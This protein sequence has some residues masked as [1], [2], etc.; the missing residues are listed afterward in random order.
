MGFRGSRVRISPARPVLRTFTFP[1]QI[2]PPTLAYDRVRRCPPTFAFTCLP[3][4]YQRTRRDVGA[5]HQA[6]RGRSGARYASPVSLGRVPPGVRVGRP[7]DGPKSLRGP[8][9]Q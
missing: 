9:P 2:V 3:C 5:T 6:L 4:A 1:S 8:V 7:R